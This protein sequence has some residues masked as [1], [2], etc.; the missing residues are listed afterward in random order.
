VDVGGFALERKLVL[1]GGVDLMQ[2]IYCC[3]RWFVYTGYADSS[4]LYS[5]LL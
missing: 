3:G 4:L 5:I 1:D 2:A